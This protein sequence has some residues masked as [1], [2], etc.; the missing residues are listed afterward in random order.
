MKR[1]RYPN[2]TFQGREV[3][4]RLLQLRRIVLW[5][6]EE[7]IWFGEDEGLPTRWHPAK[8]RSRSSLQRAVEQRPSII[9]MFLRNI[10]AKSM[11]SSGGFEKIK[12]KCS[13]PRSQWALI[14]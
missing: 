12:A 5:A 4:G 2:R 1:L 13:W 9:R 8:S 10:G 3:V 7:L 6:A 14:C 11:N